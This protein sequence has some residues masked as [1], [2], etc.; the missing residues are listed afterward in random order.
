MNTVLFLWQYRRIV[1]GL[2]AVVALITAVLWAMGTLIAHGE[3]KGRAEV[4]AAWDA[5]KAKQA[6]AVAAVR[7]QASRDVAS[8]LDVL[9]TKL[10]ARDAAT[11]AAMKG[12]QNELKNAVY[13]DCRITDGGMRLYESA[14]IASGP[15]D[16]H[17]AAAAVAV[18][19]P[20]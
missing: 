13:R 20:E 4:Q 2:L 12:L 11:A 19:S 7:E 3:T 8:A 5:E 9:D 10:S 6:A 17:P 14:G 15:A 16:R 18:P 1:G